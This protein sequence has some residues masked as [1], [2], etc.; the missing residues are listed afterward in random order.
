MTSKKM[1]QWAKESERGEVESADNHM[2]MTRTAP[3]VQKQ[4]C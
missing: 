2:T 3:S 1:G 4:L